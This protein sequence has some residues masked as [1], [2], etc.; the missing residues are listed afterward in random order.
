[1]NKKAQGIQEIGKIVLMLVF[2]GVVL[3]A[4]LNYFGIFTNQINTINTAD[5]CDQ[6][7]I[8]TDDYCPD[9]EDIDRSDKDGDGVSDFCERAR[10][11]WECGTDKENMYIDD[12]DKHP[13][14]YFTE[15][16]NKIPQCSN[17]GKAQ[18]Q[19]AKTLDNVNYQ[20][21]CQPEA[22]YGNTFDSQKRKDYL[23]SIYGKN[24]CN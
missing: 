10:A 7:K 13:K 22:D 20:L 18:L 15:N 23:L 8:K 5:N 17:I 24:P 11:V 1:M 12:K 4:L 6:D 19:L 3:F 14:K 21:I 9:L 16:C 2:V